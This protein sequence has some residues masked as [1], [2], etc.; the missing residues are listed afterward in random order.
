V[1]EE[2][3]RRVASDRSLLLKPNINSVFPSASL[4][5]PFVYR[6]NYEKN[7]EPSRM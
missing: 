6:Q 2:I 3:V 4:L 5:Q 1:G 7:K